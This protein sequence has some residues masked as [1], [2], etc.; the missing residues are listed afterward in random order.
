MRSLG[1]ITVR[2]RRINA[3]LILCAVDSALK[4]ED[5]LA[6]LHLKRLCQTCFGNAFMNVI[7]ALVPW[8]KS[9]IKVDYFP[10]RTHTAVKETALL[11]LQTNMIIS[12]HGTQII[13]LN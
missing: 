6:N 5:V 1:F 10:L 11:K 8:I 12:P 7:R 3:A 13:R 9:D 4:A 2:M